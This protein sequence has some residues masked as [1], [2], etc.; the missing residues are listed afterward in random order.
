MAKLFLLQ[1]S[2]WSKMCLLG[3]IPPNKIPSRTIRDSRT[4]KN[5][6][7]YSGVGVEKFLGSGSGTG[8]P[9]ITIPLHCASGRFVSLEH[10]QASDPI[11]YFL[12]SDVFDVR[13]YARYRQPSSLCGFFI[14]RRWHFLNAGSMCLCNVKTC[15]WSTLIVTSLADAV[16]SWLVQRLDPATPVVPARATTWEA[17]QNASLNFDVPTQ[18]TICCTHPSFTSS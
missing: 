16:D 15:S 4:P 5:L 1:K 9:Q 2:V 14:W 17:G 13:N 7:S 6:T 3:P 8:L 10:N 11:F 12:F 18:S